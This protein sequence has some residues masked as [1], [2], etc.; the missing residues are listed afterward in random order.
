[1]FSDVND[2]LQGVACPL[3]THE[4]LQEQRQSN[5]NRGG[6]G[7]LFAPSRM[8]FRIYSRNVEGVWAFVNKKKIYGVEGEEDK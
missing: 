6:E 4:F 3:V 8:S 2:V 7:G 1:M 5:E